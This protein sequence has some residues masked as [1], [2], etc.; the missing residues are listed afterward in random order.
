MIHRTEPR[1]Q[2]LGGLVRALC[3]ASQSVG[4]ANPMRAMSQQRRVTPDARRYSTRG[5][6]TDVYKTV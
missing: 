1:T 6:K 5:L 3:N 4:G 2:N